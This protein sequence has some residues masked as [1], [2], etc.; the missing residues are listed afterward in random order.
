MAILGKQKKLN[1]LIFLEV[2]RF[3]LGILTHV[4]LFPQ[5][6]R[7]VRNRK[8]CL[9]VSDLQ[10]YSKYCLRVSELQQYSKY[11]LRVSDLQQYS[12]NLC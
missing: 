11:C 6:D 1:V 7:Q 12:L 9:R 10:Q 5:V 3:I 4:I 8:Y 2:L